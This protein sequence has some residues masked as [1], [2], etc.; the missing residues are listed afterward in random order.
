MTALLQTEVAGSGVDPEG[1][2]NDPVVVKAG[3]LGFESAKYWDP[4]T[5]YISSKE[6]DCTFLAVGDASAD[7]EYLDQLW[8]Y[9]PELSPEDLPGLGAGLKGTLILHSND[10]DDWFGMYGRTE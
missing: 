1:Y 10:F 3:E 5:N 4:I 6:P 7:Q 8:K 2:E 9:P